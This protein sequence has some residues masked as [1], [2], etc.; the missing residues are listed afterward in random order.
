MV[1]GCRAARH[2]VASRT[3]RGAWPSSAA[4]D[5]YEA[6]CTTTTSHLLGEAR[7]LRPTQSDR[8]RAPPWMQNDSHGTWCY[9]S[10]MPPVPTRTSE[11]CLARN[12]AC[13]AIHFRSPIPP[14]ILGVCN[15]VGRNS[16]EGGPAGDVRFIGVQ[17]AEKRKGLRRKVYA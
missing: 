14:Q 11:T 8:A 1:S 16:C 2:A 5:G 12:E 10:G 9:Q 13:R 7:G 4:M 15:G 6:T 3:R 17:K